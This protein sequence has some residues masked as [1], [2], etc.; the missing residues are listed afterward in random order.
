MDAKH[1]IARPGQRAREIQSEG[2]TPNEA[3]VPRI[4]RGFF[5]RYDSS[6]Q[7]QLFRTDCIIFKIGDSYLDLLRVPSWML[8]KSDRHHDRSWLWGC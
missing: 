7:Q 5:D 3:H 6:E 4:A 2:S 8:R 1:R